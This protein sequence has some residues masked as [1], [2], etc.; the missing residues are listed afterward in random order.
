MQHRVISA[1]GILPLRL[2]KSLMLMLALL[3]SS[4]STAGDV[5]SLQSQM[6]GAYPDMAVHYLEDAEQSYTFDDVRQEPLASAFA[7]LPQG[8][9][10]M[11]IRHSAFWLR[12]DV[13]NS[14]AET[15]NWYL[16]AIFPQWDHVSFYMQGAQPLLLGDHQVF[17]NRPVPV[18]TYVYPVT[19]PA[20]S[21]QRIWV[22][23][24]YDHAGLSETRLRLWTPA[25][26]DQ[27]HAARYFIIG[28][29]VGLGVLLFFYNLFIGFTTR[30]YEYIWYTSYVLAAVLTLLSFTG[31]GTCYLWS[32]SI[33]FADFAPILFGMLTL[34]LATQFTRSFLNTKK[35]LPAV[36]RLLCVA[37]G[38]GVLALLVYLPGWREYAIWLLY[39][40]AGITLIFPLIGL[41]QYLHGRIDA[42]FYVLGW[43]IWSIAL[44]TAMLRNIGIIPADF[45]TSFGP[46]LGFFIEAALMSFALADRINRFRDEKEQIEIRHMNHL[47][48]QQEELERVVKERT[49]AL[50]LSK[51]Q[52]EL[53][54]RTDVLTGVL[55]RRAFFEG[56][57]RELDRARRY[58]Q[59]LSVV[60]IDID[61]FKRI[62]D[63]YGHAGGDAVLV[64]VI[65][66]LAGMVRKVDLIAR[67]GGEEFAIL[68]PQTDLT[69]AGELAGRLRHT[70]EM[71]GVGFGDD[72]IEVTASFGVACV[73]DD[74][75]LDAAL[76]RADRALYQAKENGRNRVEKSDR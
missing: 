65:G 53:L 71:L 9:S 49:A 28:A 19:T 55:T 27:H 41:R 33:W 46:P 26:F 15:L 45:F 76:N 14:G 31:I 4:V 66:K 13:R 25:A 30:L 29:F 42:R 72:L 69:T 60:M 38:A 20:G 24:A 1:H 75:S 62:N 23:F 68:L 7:M 40:C 5:F 74:E 32:A 21:E 64:G 63:R 67:M 51:Q 22:R 8:K 54:A 47:E 17:E 36:D 10:N 70:V 61:H 35:H 18:E 11:G 44:I 16:E 73:H 50:E 6:P 57:L 3:V 43:S 48:K 2:A 56:G 12:L 52:A 37:I 58:Q 39:L 34:T 59:P